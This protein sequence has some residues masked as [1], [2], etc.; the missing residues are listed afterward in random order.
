MWAKVDDKFPRHRRIRELRRDSNAKWLHVTAICH[1]CEHLTDGLIDEISLD[2]V[3]SDSD[4][5]R[6]TALRCVPKLE[7][8]GL[9]IRH[10]GRGAW[11]IRDFLD[12]NP[13]AHEVREKRE[14]RASAGRLGGIKS[15][16][17][18]REASASRV[19]RGSFGDR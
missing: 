17:A 11:L 4:I 18:R 10:E 2:Q 3:I 9:W 19:V 5:A 8:A 7:A 1:C 16:E 6:P 15:G 14:K 12:Y 13:T